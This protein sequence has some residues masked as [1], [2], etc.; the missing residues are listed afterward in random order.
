MTDD[1][2]R[3]ILL[4]IEQFKMLPVQLETAV[5]L[6]HELEATGRIDPEDPQDT[7]NEI[8]KAITDAHIAL[9]RIGAA[10]GIEFEYA[11]RMERKEAA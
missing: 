5:R 8:R 1:T 4:Y 11:Q 10:C 7:L 3:R 2:Y 6:A 9:N